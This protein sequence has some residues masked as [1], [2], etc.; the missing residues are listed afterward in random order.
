MPKELPD[1]HVLGLCAG[2]HKVWVVMSN[3]WRKKSQHQVAFAAK[4]VIGL[5]LPHRNVSD[6]HAMAYV[7]L[8]LGVSPSVYV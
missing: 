5:Q 6:A 7:W 4:N 1:F 2:A 3:H 8:Q